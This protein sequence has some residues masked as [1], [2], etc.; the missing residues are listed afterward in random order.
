MCTRGTPVWGCMCLS[1]CVEVRQQSPFHLDS[2][3][4]LR[5]SDWLDHQL[6]RIL[7][8]CLPLAAGALRLQAFVTMSRLLWDP[9]LGPRVCRP[10]PLTHWA[11]SLAQHCHLDPAELW[12]FLTAYLWMKPLEQHWISTGQL[13]GL[14]WPRLGVVGLIKYFNLVFEPHTYSWALFNSN[15]LHP[16]WLFI[17]FSTESSSSCTNSFQECPSAFPHVNLLP[18]HF[19]HGYFN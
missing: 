2:C 16:N 3:L 9:R 13:F 5:M 1:R 12:G 18:A 19:Y 6:A 14:S 17:A 8:F 15:P 4:L 10:S 7:L 11:I